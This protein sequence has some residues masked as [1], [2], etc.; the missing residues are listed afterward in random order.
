MSLSNPTPTNPAQHFFT[1]SGSKGELS[2][3]NKEK[4]QNITVPLPFEFIVLDELSTI[5]GYSDQDQSGFW[6]N[7]VRNI[8]KDELNVRTKKGTKQL[9]VYKE[10]KGSPAL[11][12]AK[13]AKSIYLAHKDKSGNY[14]MGNLKASGVALTAWIE[15]SAKHNV[16]GGKVRLTGSTDGSKGATQ[17]KI[18]TFEYDTFT[19]DEYEAAVELDKQLQMYLSQYLSI[20]EKAKIED[21]F[22]QDTE[23]TDRW[24]EPTLS[25]QDEKDEYEALQ[26]GLAAQDEFDANDLNAIFPE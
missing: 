5:T 22:N 21:H 20:S 2:F 26:S 13:Y 23:T 10:L 7:E 8:T 16:Q 17:F 25:T 15:L 4:Q 14:I 3:Y 24:N 1:W 11:T 19:P 9:G 18:P 6:S 12:G